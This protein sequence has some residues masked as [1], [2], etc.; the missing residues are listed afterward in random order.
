MTSI[1]NNLKTILNNKIQQPICEFSRK[2]SKEP[3]GFFSWLL[4]LLA[5]FK[6]KLTSQPNIPGTI[7]TLNDGY[8][9]LMLFADAKTNVTTSTPALKKNSGMKV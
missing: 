8:L 1:K 4:K 9:S 5:D 7:K 3:Q 2:F 6:K